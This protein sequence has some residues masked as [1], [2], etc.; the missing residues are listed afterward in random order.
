MEATVALVVLAVIVLVLVGYLV[1]AVRFVRRHPRPD[2]PGQAYDMG[3]AI[4]GFWRYALRKRE[5][6]SRA[7]KPTG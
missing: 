2:S 4:S 1:A 6:T 5:S 7:E 3:N